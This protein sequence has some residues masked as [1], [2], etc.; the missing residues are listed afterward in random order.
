MSIIQQLCQLIVVVMTGPPAQELPF[1]PAWLRCEVIPLPR[2][3]A[4]YHLFSRPPCRPACPA[5]GDKAR[6]PLQPPSTYG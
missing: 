2:P 1:D 6:R 5:C 4:T 3:A